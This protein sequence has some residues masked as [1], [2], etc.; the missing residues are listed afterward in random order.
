[1]MKSAVFKAIFRESAVG[2]SGYLRKTLHFPSELARSKIFRLVGHGM[3]PLHVCKVL[4]LFCKVRMRVVPRK[5]MFF[6]P[7][8]LRIRDF[9]FV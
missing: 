3:T 7:E 2:V 6:R 4:A 8:S 9:I 1:M 5:S